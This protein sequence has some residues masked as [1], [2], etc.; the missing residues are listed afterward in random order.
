MSTI[1]E[2]GNPES[3]SEKSTSSRIS[4]ARKFRTSPPMVEA[5]KAQP[6]LQPTWVEMQTVLPWR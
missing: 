6:C 3:F 4:E 1:L 5:Q 2:M